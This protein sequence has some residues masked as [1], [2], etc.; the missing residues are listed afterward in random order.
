MTSNQ[1]LNL[2]YTSDVNPEIN[3]RMLLDEIVALLCSEIN[4]SNLS[5]LNLANS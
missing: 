5:S 1:V 2:H 4:L 3:N